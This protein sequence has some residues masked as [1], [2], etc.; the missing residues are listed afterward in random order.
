MANTLSMGHLSASRFKLSNMV[1][2]IGE[3]ISWRS[4]GDGLPVTSII[5][6]SWFRVE[7]PGK[8]GLL[9]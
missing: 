7:L 6:L 4:A 3:W 1:V 8:T 2:A 9:R 5:R